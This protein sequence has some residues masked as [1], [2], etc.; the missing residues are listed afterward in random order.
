DERQLHLAR[1]EQL[2]HDL[3]PCQQSVVDDVERGRGGQGDVEVRLQAVAVAVD[4][5]LLQ[6]LLDRPTAAVLLDGRG[7]ADAFEHRDQL[8]QRVV[9]VGA[10]A[11]VVDEVEANLALAVGD[12][13][14][15]HDAPG[16]DDGRVEPSLDALVEEHRVEDVAG[17]RVHAK[18]DV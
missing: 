12:L 3:H 8:F 13:G 18:G 1:G 10:T 15:R 2:A 4:D 9:A 14:Q 11:P 7:R 16:V 5:A 6:P 17:G